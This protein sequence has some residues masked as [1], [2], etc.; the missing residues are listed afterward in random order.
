M[1]FLNAEKSLSLSIK[2]IAFLTIAGKSP[3]QKKK[4]AR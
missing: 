2:G 4:A 3:G 1:L